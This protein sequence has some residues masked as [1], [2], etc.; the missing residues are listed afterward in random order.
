M[1]LP[2]LFLSALLLLPMH[3][4]AASAAQ[5]G[6]RGPRVTGLY[7]N[8]R[9]SPESGDVG[10]MEVFVVYSGEGYF[11]VVQLAEGV[12]SPPVVAK[13]K[14]EGARIEFTLPAGGA[15]GASKFAG[16]ISAGGLT[17]RFEGDAKPTFLRR[18]Q[19]YWQ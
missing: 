11:A 1:R 8:M 5:R 13:A 16:T 14:V 10:G 18:K 19:S 9:H 6:A 15:Q 12:P 4:P 7:S 2:A 3:A 17:G